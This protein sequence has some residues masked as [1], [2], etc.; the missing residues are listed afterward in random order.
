[1]QSDIC[2]QHLHKI[3]SKSQS[4]NVIC[5]CMYMLVNVVIWAY[6]PSRVIQYISEPSLS[7][8]SSALRWPSTAEDGA[9]RL[10]PKKRGRGSILPGTFGLLSPEFGYSATVDASRAGRQ[11]LNASLSA[12]PDCARVGRGDVGAREPKQSTC[13]LC[14]TGSR[15]WVRSK[16]LD[17]SSKM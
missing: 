3:Q 17:C 15:T 16:F 4:I 2:K 6:M 5:Q 12:P 8:L 10:L 1:M 9:C 14:Q 11:L 13:T 7:R